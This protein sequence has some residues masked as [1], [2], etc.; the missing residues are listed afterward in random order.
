MF[1]TQF[2]AGQFGWV[3]VHLERIEATELA[4]LVYEAWRLTAPVRVVAAYGGQPPSLTASKRP[5]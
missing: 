3:V 5:E 2:V 4:E 1:E